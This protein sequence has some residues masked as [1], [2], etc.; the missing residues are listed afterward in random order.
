M[1]IYYFY[2]VVD[3]SVAE[4]EPLQSYTGI[5]IVIDSYIVGGNSEH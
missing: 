3:P 4:A 5:I 2:T 1:G